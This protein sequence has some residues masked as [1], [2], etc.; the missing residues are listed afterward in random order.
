MQRM[1]PHLRRMPSAIIPALL[2]IAI[3]AGIAQAFPRPSAV[4]YRWQLDF[5]AGAL[6]IYVDSS[7]GDAYWYFSYTV[8]NRTGN[9]QLWA[10]SMVLYTDEGEILSSGAGVPSSIEE[11]IRD[12]LGNP[13]LE[14]QHEII[15]D[16]LQGEEHARDG[17]AVWPVKS[18][19]VNE[20]SLLIGGLS[21]ET[22]RIRNPVTGE[23]VILRKTLKRDYLIRGD[24]LAR[25]SKPI[26]MVDSEWVL[27]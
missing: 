13:L 23:S 8:T 5:N 21:G 20:L 6:R 17:L 19:K 11:D 9:D 10:P 26:E 4:P 1:T 14:L 16:I 22:A 3:L 25:G 27:R 15:G 7:T 24:A 18:R 2:G 12:L